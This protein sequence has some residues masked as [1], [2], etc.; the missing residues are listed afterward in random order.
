MIP[1]ILFATDFSESSEH[2]LPVATALAAN[3]QARLLIAHVS[4]LQRGA[5]PK[6]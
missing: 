6:N 3:G 2:A 1:T 4:E 5:S